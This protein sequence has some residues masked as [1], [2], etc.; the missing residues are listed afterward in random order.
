[1]FNPTNKIKEQI[2]SFLGAVSFYTIVPLPTHWQPNYL[3]VARWS[4]LIGILIGG[5]LGS[6][7]LIL[8]YLNL[9]NLTR[10]GLIVALWLYLTGGLHLDGV[11]DTADGL[12][13]SDP[14]RRL[15]VMQDSH[16]GAFG[17]MA[18][19]IVLLLKTLA[20]NDLTHIRTLVLMAAAG[21]GR[22]GQIIAIAIYPYLKPTG[23]GAFHQQNIRL[24]QDVFFGLLPLIGINLG[25]LFFEPQKW[26]IALLIFVLGLAIA[27]LT[28]F[29]FHQKLG[30]HTGDTYGAVV[31]WTEVIYLCCLT[32]LF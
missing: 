32:G 24:P 11:M 20:L 3:R 22:W 27:F 18:G 12:G 23:K 2:Q 4:S 19:V 9:P 28:G 8:A 17:V 15:E 30:G 1:M 7:D 16:S 13:V 5:F 26:A 29:W 6:I 10:S 21:W 31:E 14:K 25:Y